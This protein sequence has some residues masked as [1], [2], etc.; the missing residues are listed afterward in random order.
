MAHEREPLNSAEDIVAPTSHEVSDL[1]GEFADG[2]VKVFGELRETAGRQ[3]IPR[4]GA[5]RTEIEVGSAIVAVH[6]ERTAFTGAIRLSQID[7]RRG[8]EIHSLTVQTDPTT[9][10]SNPYYIFFDG[11]TK[12]GLGAGQRTDLALASELVGQRIPEGSGNQLTPAVV[13]WVKGKLA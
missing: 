6:R 4:D 11:E 2:K 3:Y 1:I 10:P 8:K 7:V 5:Q 12:V 9:S 13:N